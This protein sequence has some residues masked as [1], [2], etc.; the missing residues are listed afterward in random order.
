MNVRVEYE[1]IPIRHIAVQCPKCENWFGGR[2]IYAG[3]WTQGLR[4]AHEI[5]FATFIC[6]LCDVSFGGIQNAENVNIEETGYPEVYENCLQ[7]KE[8]WA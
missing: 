1:S 6:P 2:D 3:D 5:K 7:R 8:I 4:Y